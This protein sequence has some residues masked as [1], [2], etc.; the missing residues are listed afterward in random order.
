MKRLEAAATRRLVP[1]LLAWLATGFVGTALAQQGGGTRFGVALA[2]RLWGRS[3]IHR[4]QDAFWRRLRDTPSW[5]PPPR[6]ATCLDAGLAPLHWVEQRHH[7][8]MTME[9]AQAVLPGS[10]RRVWRVY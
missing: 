7:L 2:A 4:R 3:R 1:L 5:V 6:R 10:S 9:H 8:S